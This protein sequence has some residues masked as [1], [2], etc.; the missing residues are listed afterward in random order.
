MNSRLRTNSCRHVIRTP[1]LH[2]AVAAAAA[3]AERWPQEGW[4]AWA[5]LLS[6]S[7][8]GLEGTL[9]RRHCRTR[10]PRNP[11]QPAHTFKTC[12]QATS[13]RNRQE[14]G[15]RRLGLVCQ[16]RGL[17]SSVYGG[18]APHGTLLAESPRDKMCSLHT[19]T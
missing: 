7:P 19:G 14:F 12:Q 4:V 3:A 9:I 16:S 6:G 8:R 11:Y 10:H 2:M 15:I 18:I 5:L 17:A 1:G 13:L